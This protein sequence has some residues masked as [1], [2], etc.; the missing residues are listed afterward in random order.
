MGAEL[1]YVLAIVAHTPGDPNIGNAPY[2]SFLVESLTN[3]P[4]EGPAAILQSIANAGYNSNPNY[5]FDMADY[6]PSWAK[7]SLNSTMQNILNC[8]KK[9]GYI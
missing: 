3:N 9:N 7:V 8:L 1:T 4:N 6:V 5:G 2:S